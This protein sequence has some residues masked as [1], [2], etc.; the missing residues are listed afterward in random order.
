VKSNGRGLKKDGSKSAT[1]HKQDSL[2]FH[3]HL[4]AWEWVIWNYYN[5]NK[6]IP[7]RTGSIIPLFPADPNLTTPM[8]K[9]SGLVGLRA[10]L[11]EHHCVQLD[12]AAEAEVAAW[13]N[14][15]YLS[16]R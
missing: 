7:M 2:G 3:Q 12:S 14:S 6:G 11:A 16:C 13:V 15:L 4:L 10:Q 8:N 9:R 5:S 1:C